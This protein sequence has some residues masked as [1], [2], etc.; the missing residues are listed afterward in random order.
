MAWFN[1]E[2]LMIRAGVHSWLGSDSSPN[3]QMDLKELNYI[4]N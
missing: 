3:I 1:L 4:K 2:R